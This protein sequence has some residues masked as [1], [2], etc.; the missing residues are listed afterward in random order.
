[1]IIRGGEN[2][3]PREIEDVLIMH[4]GVAE[5][6]VIGVPDDRWGEQPIAYIRTAV[7]AGT[8]SEAELVAFVREHIAPHKRPRQWFFVDSFPMNA[9]GKVQKFL[10]RE[11]Y[12]PAEPNGAVGAG[13]SAP[14]SN[15]GA[16]IANLRSA[17]PS[18]ALQ[19]RLD[20]IDRA[21]LDNTVGFAA[22][23]TRRYI[24]TN[25]ADDGWQGPVRSSC[26]T[27]RAGAVGRFGA[28]PSCTSTWAPVDSWLPP[29]AERPRIR[30]GTR[31]SWPIRLCT[32]GS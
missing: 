12:D 21:A 5:A 1:M 22:E 30:L 10:L 25:G 28:T 13:P 11:Q 24:A 6:A 18:A 32:C 15:L 29:R 7:G 14:A 20:E 23:H 26:S 16:W 17:D 27:R 3:F 19:D 4:P 8:P 9:S 2:I 31:I